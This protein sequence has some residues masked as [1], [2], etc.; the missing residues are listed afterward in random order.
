M[1]SAIMGFVDTYGLDRSVAVGSFM[2]AAAS[3]LVTALGFAVSIP[4][5]FIARKQ[6]KLA[7][8][9]TKLAREQTEQAR[10]SNIANGYVVTAAAI[11]SKWHDLHRARSRVTTDQRD[12]ELAAKE[13]RLAIGELLNALEIGC[14]VYL[15]IATECR[16]GDA[17]RGMLKANSDLTVD[18]Q[19]INGKVIEYRK[20]DKDVFCNIVEF[21]R[22][23]P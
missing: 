17:F 2:I 15:D 11:S 18:D 3:L 20:D 6:G 14:A 12:Q 5:L 9:Q 1:F 13:Q 23:N 22:R 4:S 16:T 19:E 21:R 8:E 10:I 7:N